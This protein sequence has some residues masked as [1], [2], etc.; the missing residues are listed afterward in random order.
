MQYNRPGWPVAAK[1]AYGDRVQRSAMGNQPPAYRF[2]S[3]VVGWYTTSG[4]LGYVVALDH[5]PGCKQI[6]PEKMLEPWE[7]DAGRL[8]D[9]APEMLEFV[10]E[11]ASYPHGGA[12]EIGD[13]RAHQ[14]SDM[15]L[16]ARSLLRKWG[17]PFNG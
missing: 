9:S 8:S 10:Q 7:G 15:I 17:F 13:A 4:G 2:R 16:G 11:C 12:I 3:R 6:F 14:W 5:D 1:F